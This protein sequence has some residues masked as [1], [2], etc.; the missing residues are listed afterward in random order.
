[1]LSLTSREAGFGLTEWLQN[2]LFFCFSVGFP[3]TPLL[4]QS[5]LDKEDP[6]FQIQIHHFSQIALF[7]PLKSNRSPPSA[8]PSPTTL[9]EVTD[10]LTK[11]SLY[12][13]LYVKVKLLVDKLLLRE[14]SF[15]S[16]SPNNSEVFCN[17]ISVVERPH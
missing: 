16:L 5:K 1:M 3:H 17:G 13:N 14:F 7:H 6:S 12:H 10:N 8:H 2:Q 4:Q 9:G 15:T 11:L